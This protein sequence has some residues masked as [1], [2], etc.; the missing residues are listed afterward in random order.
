VYDECG[1]CNGPGPTVQVIDDIIIELDSVFIDVLE[2]WY[3]FESSVDT[4]YSYLCGPVQCNGE[5]FVTYQDHD[6]GLIGI[7]NQCWFKENLRNSNYANGEEIPLIEDSENWISS[8]ANGEGA[9][10]WLFYDS[11]SFQEYGLLYNWYTVVDVRGVC[12]TGWHVPNDE[13]YS[14]LTDL[15]GPT[16]V[17]IKMKSSPEDSPAW[18]GTNESAYSGLPGQFI[19]ANG[20]SNPSL[21]DGYWWSATANSFEHAWGRI[22]SSINVDCYRGDILKSKGQSVRCMKGEPTIGCT[23]PDACNFDYTAHLDDG[24]CEWF[25][26]CGVCGG[27][28]S[29]CLDGCG[30]PN[31]VSGCTDNLSSNYNSLATCDDGSCMPYVGMYGLG[32]VIYRISGSTAYIVNVHDEQYTSRTLSNCSGIVNALTTNGYTDWQ[33]PSETELDYICP[34][35]SFVDLI[36]NGYSGTVTFGSNT[37][38]VSSNTYCNGSNAGAG[39]YCILY[40][41]DNAGGSNCML[42]GF[43][44]NCCCQQASGFLRSIRIQTF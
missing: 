5:L 28:N 38:Y 35:S 26:E 14:V 4:T 29:T 30:V 27:D 39:P 34:Q 7:G 8:A 15:L 1:V 18:D 42:G 24:S 32:G 23:N 37:P 13:E 16:N 40:Y 2:E 9:S 44:G 41:F 33:I 12:P 11:E 3:V 10:A 20:T 25:D 31:G 17:G 43:T 36:A 21:N 19:N 6:Y 22:L